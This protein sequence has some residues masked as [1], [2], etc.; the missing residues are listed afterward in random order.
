[1][2]ISY[3]R[4]SFHSLSVQIVESFESPITSNTTTA[5][6][7]LLPPN[8]AAVLRKGCVGQVPFSSSYYKAVCI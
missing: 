1:M 6:D 8:S 2:L 3:L 5:P 7:F 4:C